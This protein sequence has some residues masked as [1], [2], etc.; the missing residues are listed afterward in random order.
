MQPVQS[1]RVRVCVFVLFLMFP[2]FPL[3]E[4]AVLPCAPL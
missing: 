1:V 3:G 2:V 4:E